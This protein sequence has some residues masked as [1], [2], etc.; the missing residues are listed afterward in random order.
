MAALPSYR[1][2]CTLLIRSAYPSLSRSEQKVAK[3]IL[4]QP[5]EVIYLSITE[6]ADAAG[7]GEATISRLCQRLNFRGFQDLKLALAQ[8]LVPS[9]LEDIGPPGE[10]ELPTLTREVAQR[11]TRVIQ[12]TALLL[13]MEEVDKAINL[14]IGARKIDCYGVGASG[15]T[16]LIAEHK[17]LRMGR[18]CNAFTDPHVQ[19]MS[20]ALLTLRDVVLIFS[21]SGSTKDIMA[22]LMEAKEHGASSICV[23]SVARSP[24]ARASDVVL[25]AATGETTLVTTLHS[26]IAQLFVLEVLVEGCADRL[27]LSAEEAVSRTTSAVIDRMF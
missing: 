5:E 27:G 24:I 11:S 23:T 26:S 17:F 18:L 6:V 15:L 3:Y 19:T 20:A 21:H 4:G 16:A 9:M 10:G 13:D 2:G 25:L 22:S 8:E 12:E 14:L 1:A 7:V